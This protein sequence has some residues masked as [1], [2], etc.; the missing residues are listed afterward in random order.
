MNAYSAELDNL[1][2]NY[3]EQERKLKKL[4]ETEKNIEEENLLLI[5]ENQK[6][7]NAQINRDENGN[8]VNSQTL[9]KIL[10]QVRPQDFAD[11]GIFARYMK[12]K[13]FRKEKLSML[14]DL[15]EAKKWH[16]LDLAQ[17]HAQ[18]E[19]MEL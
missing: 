3:A 13:V 16:Q 17:K 6:R 18:E 14:Q 10:N 2:Y 1:A 15:H 19:I 8:R 9:V 12:N 11:D 4:Q 5:K 7:L